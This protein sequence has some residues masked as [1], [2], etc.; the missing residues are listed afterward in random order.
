M[1]QKSGTQYIMSMISK[2]CPQ[3]DIN[4]NSESRVDTK[5][6]YYLVHHLALLEIL[7]KS[8]WQDFFSCAVSFSKQ[9]Y[10]KFEAYRICCM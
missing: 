5:G 10:I 8:Y 7:E 4:V 6:Y 9:G 3:Q 1:N 2:F